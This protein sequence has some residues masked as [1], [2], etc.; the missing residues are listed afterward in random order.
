MSY[1]LPSPQIDT[2]SFASQFVHNDTQELFKF[3]LNRYGNDWY[4]AKNVIVYR[5]N[6]LGYRM[7]ELEDVDFNNYYAFFGCSFTVGTGLPIE[8]TFPY[9]I[10]KQ[11]NVDYVNAGLAGASVEVVFYNIITLLNNAPM[12]PKV[13]IINWPELYR[14]MYWEKDNLVFMSPNPKNPSKHWLNSYSEFITEDSN[15]INRF[16]MIQTT[17][18][19]LCSSMGIKLFQLSSFQG[20]ENFKQLFPDIK[21]PPIGQFKNETVETM[22]LNKARDVSNTNPVSSHPGLLHQELIVNEFFK[23]IQ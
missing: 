20:L 2:H 4:W 16:R 9:K 11:S 12:K 14:T 17:V 18:K 8:D 10:A 3:N 22:H 19:L 7:K 5:F 13:I 1:L 21:T 15:V 6:K 23:A